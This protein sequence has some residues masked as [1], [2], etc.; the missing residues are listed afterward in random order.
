MGAELLAKNCGQPVEKILKDF[1]RDYWMDATGEYCL[2]HC[3]WYSGE[4]VIFLHINLLKNALKECIFWFCAI[5]CMCGNLNY[6]SKL[7]LC[8][9]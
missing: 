7:F 6:R 9:E 1:D 8:K 4:V 5:S 2:R 3:R